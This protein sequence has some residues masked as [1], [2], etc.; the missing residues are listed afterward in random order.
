MNL[1]MATNDKSFW[2]AVATMSW[3]GVIAG[4][5]FRQRPLAQLVPN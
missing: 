2:E 5:G 3:Y 1:S 4:N